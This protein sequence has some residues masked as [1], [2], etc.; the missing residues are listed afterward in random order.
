MGRQK[1]VIKKSID[2]LISDYNAKVVPHIHQVVSPWLKNYESAINCKLSDFVRTGSYRKVCLGNVYFSIY[3]LERLTQFY[4]AMAVDPLFGNVR[5]VNSNIG[6]NKWYS[7]IY[8]D[9]KNKYQ[10]TIDEYD[11]LYGS[12]DYVPFLY[13]EH[14]IKNHTKRLVLV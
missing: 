9:F 4:Q 8:S 10:I 14:E 1:E 12:I 2:W 11:N 5:I 6:E 13:N 3:T 7:S